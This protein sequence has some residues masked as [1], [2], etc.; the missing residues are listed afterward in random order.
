MVRAHPKNA[1]SSYSPT[2]DSKNVD[3]TMPLLPRIGK[4]EKILMV[5]V[6]FVRSIV[7]FFKYMV[8]FSA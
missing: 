8:Y 7:T 6:L 1:V 2:V 5:L 3:S 4:L